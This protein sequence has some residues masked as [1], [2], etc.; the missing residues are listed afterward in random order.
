VDTG[1]T[2]APRT[3]RGRVGKGRDYIR[4]EGDDKFDGTSGVA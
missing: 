3:R 1:R 2:P 4:V